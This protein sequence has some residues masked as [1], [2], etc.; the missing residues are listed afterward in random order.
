MARIPVW[1]TLAE[2]KPPSDLVVLR[3]REGIVE[4]ARMLDY[5]AE[6]GMWNELTWLVFNGDDADYEEARVTDLW[7]LLPP[8]EY[9]CGCD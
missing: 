4:P 1:I 3:E 7:R 9:G 2:S 5:S 6:N 8:S